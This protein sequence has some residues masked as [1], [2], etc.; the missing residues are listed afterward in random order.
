MSVTHQNPLDLDDAAF[1]R[2]AQDIC[3]TK[4]AHT[5]RAE[6]VAMTKRHGF[7]GTP[8]MCPWCGHW[9]TTSYDRARAKA[10][11]R[12]LSRLLRAPATSS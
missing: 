2:R 12:R 1:L 6:A 8:Y 5:S 11:T 4:A 10:F 7:S 3:T 9:H